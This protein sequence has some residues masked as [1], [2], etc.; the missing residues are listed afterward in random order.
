MIDESLPHSCSVVAAQRA[1][2]LHAALGQ[3]WPVLG[4]AGLGSSVYLGAAGSTRAREEVLTRAQYGRDQCQLE[5]KAPAN[6]LQRGML[7][8]R[9]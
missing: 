5:V 2:G 4:P 6:V 8:D 1:A 9:A 7:V 3:P